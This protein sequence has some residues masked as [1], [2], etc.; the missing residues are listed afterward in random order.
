MAS[1]TYPLICSGV[2]ILDVGD[3]ELGVVAETPL[4]LRLIGE[5]REPFLLL[6]QYELSLEH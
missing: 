4:R 3:V 1:S 2:S 6:Y 5:E